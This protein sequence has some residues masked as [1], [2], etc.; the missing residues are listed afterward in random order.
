MMKVKYHKCGDMQI[1][2]YNS[3]IQKKF[4]NSSTKSSTSFVDMHY[5]QN[6]GK[7]F[8]MSFDD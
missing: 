7:T 2:K 1:C 8:E 4:E 6:N 5:M 3:G